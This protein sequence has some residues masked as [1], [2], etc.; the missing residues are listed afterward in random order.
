[1]MLRRKNCVPFSKLIAH[2]KSP[3]KSLCLSSSTI[4]TI[5]VSIINKF[6]KKKVNLIPTFLTARRATQFY[7]AKTASLCDIC[8]EDDCGETCKIKASK[9]VSERSEK[10]QVQSREADAK[11]ASSQLSSPLA[12]FALVAITKL[13]LRV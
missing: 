9:R 1:M 5:I 10:T 13:F 12:I 6:V 4:I 8:D 2:T 7:S 3:N 11:D